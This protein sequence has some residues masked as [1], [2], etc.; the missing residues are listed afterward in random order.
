MSPLV[1]L[2][3]SH[4]GEQGRQH[5]VDEVFAACRGKVGH[6]G[7][8]VRP[9][10]EVVLLELLRAEAREPELLDLRD[11][12]VGREVGE[13]HRRLAAL[14]RRELQQRPALASFFCVQPSVFGRTC[15]TGRAWRAATRTPRIGQDGASKS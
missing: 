11:A 8:V 7:R 1:G 5:P 6:V 9:V 14:R 3:P 12:L 10:R 2:E 4:L 15:R 13:V